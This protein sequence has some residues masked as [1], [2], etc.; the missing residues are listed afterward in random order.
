MSG[1][2]L[3]RFW[4]TAGV[5]FAASVVQAAPWSDLISLKHVDTDPAKAYTLSEE[6]GPWMVMTSSFSGKGAEKQARELVLELRKRYKLPAYVYVGHFDPGK[7]EVR[8]VDKFGKKKKGVYYKYRESKN[9]EHPDLVEV[10]VLVGNYRSA[11]DPKAQ[12]VLQTL[13]YAKP[14]CLDVKDGK[15][16]SQNL[17]G[18]RLAQQQVYEMIGSKKKEMGP[19]S[20]S[21]IVPNPMLPPEYFNQRGLDEETIALNKD[22]PYSLLECSGKYT[23]QVATFKGNAVIRQ[24]DIQDIEE[25]RKE[26]KNQLAVAAQKADALAKQLRQLG[27]DAFQYHDRYTSIVTVGN[28]R[29]PGTTLPDGQID[30][31]PRIK[32]TIEVFSAGDPDSD[33]LRSHVQSASRTLSS[34]GINA[35]GVAPKRINVGTNKAPIWIP[36][37]PQPQV[38]QIPKRPISMSSG[39]VE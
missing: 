37:D 3:F 12:S 5:L 32:R 35:Q 2:S 13:K 25:G 17:T 31:D 36:L 26:M 33:P 22:V 11:D 27:Y 8:G 23:V 14:Q 18:W 9:G 28:Y 34:Q 20:H 19:M 39:G 21:F 6:N 4:M 15:T 1:K 24:S 7:A 30:F 38:V 10:A 29:S 16:T